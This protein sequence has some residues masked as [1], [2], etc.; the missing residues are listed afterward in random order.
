MRRRKS[1]SLEDAAAEPVVSLDRLIK[2]DPMWHMHRVSDNF[3]DL[4][5]LLDNSE[6]RE[7]TINYDNWFVRLAHLSVLPFSSVC[8]ARCAVIR[9]YVSHSPR[10]TVNIAL[11][12]VILL[13]GAAYDTLPIVGKSVL[14]RHTLCSYGVKIYSRNFKRDRFNR[15]DYQDTLGLLAH[16][17][18]ANAKEGYCNN[19]QRYMKWLYREKK[20]KTKKGE[21]KNLSYSLTYLCFID[22]D[23]R[24]WNSKKRRIHHAPA[25]LYRV[26]AWLRAHNGT[27]FDSCARTRL[28]VWRLLLNEVSIA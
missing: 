24:D 22:E 20:K 7:T 28:C 12:R 10:S 13:C 4:C 16:A 26:S 21:E 1:S 2:I 25:K 19:K 5:M 14:M 11:G 23:I 18:S 27:T 9:L 15:R 17:A 3:S 6:V 8:I